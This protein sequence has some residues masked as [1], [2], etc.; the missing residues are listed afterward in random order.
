MKPNVLLASVDTSSLS[1]AARE[2]LAKVLPGGGEGVEEAIGPSVV[3]REVV[4]AGERVRY[5]ATAGMIP[6]RDECGKPR[7]DMFYVA[8]ERQGVDT[9]AERPIAFVFNGGPG[10]S[11][12][13]LH[14]GA[15]GPRRV[16]FGP[17]GEALPPPSVLVDN[18]QSWLDAMDMVFIDP[19]STGF[20]RAAEGQNATQFHD[21][22]EDIRSIGDFIRLYVT[23][24]ERWLSP[25]FIVGESYGTTRAAGLAAHLQ[26]EQ[27][28]YVNG[29]VLVSPALDFA[30]LEFD[31]TNDLPYWLALPTYAATAWY[32]KKIKGEL[33]AVISE[34]E[35]FAS[36]EYLTALA[37]GDS[38]TP[39]AFASVAEKL[40]K[41][42]GLPVEIV[43][44]ARLRIGDGL[45]YKELLREEG[46]T[47]GRLDSR[48]T[49]IDKDGVGAAPDYDASFAAILGPYTG[50]LNAY[51]RE[52]LKV[53][54]DVKYEIF[55][56]KANLAW[57]LQATNRYAG[58]AESLRKAMT[59]NPA[60][61]VLVCNGYFDVATPHFASDYVLSH[62]GLAAGLRANVRV[63]RYE[64]GHMM[65]VR[66]ADLAK[67]RRDGVG[68]VTGGQAAPV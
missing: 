56:E 3:E 9:A 10:S 39:A 40:A 65:Y 54:S 35:A 64:S 22:N 51:M 17:E 4:I 57:N 23:R 24:H 60:L 18:E 1:E 34:A 43:R 45:F 38:L 8:Y 33:R 63:E 2:A 14:L 20:S 41:L 29:L 67:F 32:H 6:L 25:K 55:S 28:M 26:A 66:E 37:K 53:R 13:W 62:L 19:V 52:E 68:F 50:A 46:K 58:T 21:L 7:A 59:E 42:T 36:G 11:S 16:K 49:G 31:G 48:Y 5:R 30:T 47:V 15:M 27:G 61:R 12:V 44:R